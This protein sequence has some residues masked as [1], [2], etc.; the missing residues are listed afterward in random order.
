[1]DAV[2][3]CLAWLALPLVAAEMDGLK[4]GNSSLGV[5]VIIKVRLLINH[6]DTNKLANYF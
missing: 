2:A 3:V 6:C 4:A 1:M 5:S